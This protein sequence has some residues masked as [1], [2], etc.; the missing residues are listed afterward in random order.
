MPLLLVTYDLGKTGT[1]YP[2][3]LKK[4][5]RYSN[6]RITESSYAIIT[7]KSPKDVCAEMQKYVDGENTVYVITLNR[8][9]EASDM[10]YVS[11]WLNK[12]LTYI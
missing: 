5:N 11:D 7:D 9:Y 6:I 10:N 8:P 1:D 2:G 4:I 3:L 12:E